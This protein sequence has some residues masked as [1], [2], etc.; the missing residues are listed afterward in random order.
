MVERTFALRVHDPNPVVIVS[1]CSDVHAF[2]F[3]HAWRWRR[4]PWFEWLLVGLQGERASRGQRYI[5]PNCTP[6][7]PPEGLF[8]VHTGVSPVLEPPFDVSLGGSGGKDF[9]ALFVLSPLYSDDL[10]RNLHPRHTRSEE[11]TSELQS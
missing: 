2:L 3:I 4:G 1:L 10:A 5:P 9:Y 11:H 7:R 8:R 6:S